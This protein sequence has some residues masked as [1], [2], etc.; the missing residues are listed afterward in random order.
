MIKLTK[1][2]LEV[3]TRVGQPLETY[4]RSSYVDEHKTT[5]EIA[6]EL[7]VGNSTVGNWL[8]FQGIEI[9]TPSESRLPQGFVKPS[10]ERL[11]T[12]YVNEHKT[13]SEIAE[14]IGVSNPTVGIWLNDY[15]IE[16]RTPSESRL[17]QGFVKP[18]EEKCWKLKKELVSL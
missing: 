7:G 11:R 14:E 4:L 5:T 13:T 9:R 6:E 2:M 8:K 18:S 15:G 16:I 10:E 17:P 1:K 12:L 3:E